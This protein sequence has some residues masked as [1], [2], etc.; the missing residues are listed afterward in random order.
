MAAV[1]AVDVRPPQRQCAAFG[2]LRSRVLDALV[3]GLPTEV[4]AALHAELQAWAGEQLDGMHGEARGVRFPGVPP[5]W[6]ETLGWSGVPLALSGELTW[7]SDLLEAGVER[8][9]LDGQRLLLPPVD[10][11]AELS[12]LAMKPLRAWLGL[13][14]GCRLQASP[15]LRLYLWRDRALLVSH[16]DM[17]VGGFLYGPLAGSRAS[18]AIGAGGF[19]LVTW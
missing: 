8:P 1:V 12:G 2:Q 18:L 14:L 17:P 9:T 19:Q 5:A 13:R 7:G 6:I 4:P 15:G 16:L 10:H 3:L 11:L